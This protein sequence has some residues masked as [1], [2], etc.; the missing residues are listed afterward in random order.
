MTSNNPP[1]GQ[2]NPTGQNN[3]NTSQTQTSTGGGTSQPAKIEKVS[4]NQGP[5]ITKLPELLNEHNWGPWKDRIA[6]TL[7]H[8]DVEEYA[9]GTIQRPADP[10]QAKIWDYNDNHA[11][12]LILTNISDTE[13]IYVGHLK[14][15]NAI[16]Q[17]LAAIHE[18]TGHQTVIAIIRNLF[19]TIAG[20]DTNI[21]EHLT[22][23][24]TYWERINLLGDQDF[25][26]SDLLFKIIISS[27]LLLAW[28]VFT[29]P[30]VS[31]CR[32]DATR[33]PKRAMTSQQFIGI[34][35]EEYE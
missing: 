28:D 18:T 13:M 23:L 6:R 25:Q 30:Y 15:T 12:H 2:N 10:A 24:K 9:M 16:W 1:A 8:C 26:I 35:K 21:T 7:R 17:G 20:D 34:L 19:H 31:G 33:D 22:S 27:S 3:P 14:T 4:A 29:E 5:S 11:Q 32:G